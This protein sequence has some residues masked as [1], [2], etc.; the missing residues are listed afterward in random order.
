[1]KITKILSLAAAAIFAVSC[2]NTECKTEDNMA[3]YQKKYTNADFYKDGVFQEEVAKQAFIEM[4]EYYGYPITDYLKANWWFMDFQLGDFEHC[5]M[6]GVFWVNDPDFKYFAHDIYLLPGQM[7][8]EH[9][10]NKTKFDAK[11]ESW[12]VRNGDVKNFA[13]KLDEK[14][15][16]IVTEGYEQ[17]IPESQKAT[18]YSK[19]YQDQNLGEIV[20]LR[21]AGVN[22]KGEGT[23]HFLVAGPQGAIVHEYA[24]YHDGAW[25]SN[26]KAVM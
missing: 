20:H 10:H 14:G 26:P 1:M 21:D 18:T 13:Y 5:G 22:E 24:N 4:F 7:L 17:F 2:C 9:K 25:F 8:P 19:F 11:M 6:G 12:M 3:T 23:W 16:V 15:E